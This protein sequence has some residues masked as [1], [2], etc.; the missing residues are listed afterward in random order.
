MAPIRCEE[1]G[2]GH[3]QPQS[4][5]FLLPLGSRMMVIPEAPAYCCDVCGFRTFDEEF[6]HAIHSLLTQAAATP[7]R[8]PGSSTDRRVMGESG[9]RIVPPTRRL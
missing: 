4:A 5:P 8:S 6:L 9:R 1:C 7:G 3:F 2:I